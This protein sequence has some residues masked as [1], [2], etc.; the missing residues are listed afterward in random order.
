M[1]CRIFFCPVPH[2]CTMV[3]NRRKW[4]MTSVQRAAA[5]LKRIGPKAVLAI[6][7]LAVAAVPAHASLVFNSTSQN[8]TAPN[9]LGGPSGTPQQVPLLGSLITGSRLYDLNDVGFASGVGVVTFDI[10]QSGNGAGSTIPFPNPT[11]NGAYDFIVTE[12]GSSDLI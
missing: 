12:T 11:V 10:F 6:V 2:R 8:A 3:K 9:T 1:P 5:Y 7:P 4:T